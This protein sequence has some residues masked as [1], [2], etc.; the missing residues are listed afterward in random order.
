MKNS[1]TVVYVNCK[2]V[3]CI[4]RPIVICYERLTLLVGNILHVVFIVCVRLM[5]SVFAMKTAVK[6]V[7]KVNTSATRVEVMSSTATSAAVNVR[8][9]I[10]L[11]THFISHYAFSQH[12]TRCGT[13]TVQFPD[14][15]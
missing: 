12:T 6:S 15:A 5:W 4:G 2:T 9:D 8:Y 1:P 13:H 11:H 10:F 3:H 14:R 7:T